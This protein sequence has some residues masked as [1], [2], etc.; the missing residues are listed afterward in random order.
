[1]WEAGGGGGG[2]TK[3]VAKNTQINNNTEVLYI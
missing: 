1:M 2:H 3:E